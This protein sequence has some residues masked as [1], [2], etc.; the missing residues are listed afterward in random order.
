M[1]KKTSSS[2]LGLTGVLTVV[3]IVLKLV[4]VINWSWWW[5][6]SPLL[7]DIGLSIIILAIIGI[8]QIVRSKKRKS[9]RSKLDKFNRFKQ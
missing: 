4:G 7:I 6:L 2:G 5:V 1:N 3:F 9:R 8:F